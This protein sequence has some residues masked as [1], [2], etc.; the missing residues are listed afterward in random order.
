MAIASR[1]VLALLLFAS[2]VIVPAWADQPVPELRSPVTDVTGTL[3]PQQ[4]VALE[5]KL[6]AFEARKGAQVA[7]LIVRTTAPETIEQYA[8][9]VL[10]VWK[11]GRKDIDDGAL[12]LVAVDDHAVRIETQ[13]GFEGAL[14]DAIASRIIRETIVPQFKAGN[15]YSGVDAGIDRMLGVIDGEALPPPQHAWRGP[16]WDQWLPLLFMVAV[17]VPSILRR[18]LGRGVG[19]AASAGIA[20]VVAWLIAHFLPVAIGVGVVAFLVAIFGGTGP[21]RWTGGGRGFG[22]GGWGGGGWSSGG[23]F[24]GGGGGWSGGGGG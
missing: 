7:V 19:S 14:P 11:L 17:I 2:A 6:R 22:G 10:D 15:F 1:I 4:S 20:G 18:M 23:G 5:A 13:Y 21:G 16:G 9:R 24:G 8:R 12:L 3:T